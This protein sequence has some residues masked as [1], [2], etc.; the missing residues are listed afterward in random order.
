MPRK[1]LPSTWAVEAGI[2][3]LGLLVDTLRTSLVVTE[4]VSGS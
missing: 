1:P 3:V 2:F 4:F